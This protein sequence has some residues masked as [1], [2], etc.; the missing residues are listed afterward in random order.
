MPVRAVGMQ[1]GSG[2]GRERAAR[3]TRLG[4]IAVT[5]DDDDVVAVDFVKARPGSA[6]AT[7]PVLRR[8]QLQIDEYLKGRR[9]RFTV[10]VELCGTPFQLVVWRAIQRIPYGETRT[11]AQ[12]AASIRRPDSARAVGS[13]C[14][15]NPVSIMIPC[16]RVVGKGGELTGYGGGLWRKKWLLEHEARGARPKRR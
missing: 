4:V 5:V 2:A 7:S 12:L 13:A 16:H 6:R 3:R 15:A 1:R 8:A 9:K 11:Y 10:P 14:R